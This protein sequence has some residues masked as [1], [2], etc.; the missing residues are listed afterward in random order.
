MS[1]E[2]GIDKVLAPL[3]LHPLQPVWSDFPIKSSPIILKIAQMVAIRVL[4]LH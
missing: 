1:G 3:R 4:K 2:G